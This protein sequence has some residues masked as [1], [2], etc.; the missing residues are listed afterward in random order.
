MLA[1]KEN[2]LSSMLYILSYTSST[3][4]YV[5]TSQPIRW[6]DSYIY[7]SEIYKSGI[8]LNHMPLTPL[9]LTLAHLSQLELDREVSAMNLNM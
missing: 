5:T 2:L 1:A 4:G 9:N 7:V 8:I 6:L 3:Q